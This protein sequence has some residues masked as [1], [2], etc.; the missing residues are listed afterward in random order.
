[1]PTSR[2]MLSLLVYVVFPDDFNSSLFHSGAHIPLD[3]PIGD[4]PQPQ[5]KLLPNKTQ[6]PLL[7]S[8][9]PASSHLPCW[10]MIPVI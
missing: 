8:L 6:S 1:M 5:T 2:V 4:V 7:A 9:I 3:I 10:K